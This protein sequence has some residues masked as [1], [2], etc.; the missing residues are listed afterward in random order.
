[1]DGQHGIFLSVVDEKMQFEQT[2]HRIE[3][4]LRL[5]ELFSVDDFASEQ[6]VVVEPEEIA[7]V[8]VDLEEGD[9]HS[10]IAVAFVVEVEDFGSGRDVLF[11]IELRK[12]LDGCFGCD[13]RKAE[14]DESEQHARLFQLN[15]VSPLQLPADIDVFSLLPFVHWSNQS[16]AFLLIFF[17]E[18]Q[19]R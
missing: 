16:I 5:Q 3:A 7:L 13:Q 4:S 12:G 9:F 6:F 8:S 14:E 18:R 17:A 10:S 1:M 15:S 11:E 2:K 19:I